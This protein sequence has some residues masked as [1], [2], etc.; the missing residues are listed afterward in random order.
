MSGYGVLGFNSD[1]AGGGALDYIQ[2]AFQDITVPANS[3]AGFSSTVLKNP[4]G[5]Y[6]GNNAAPR[7]GAK[8]LWIKDLVPLPPEKQ[9]ATYLGITQ[10]PTYQI[11][12]HED[13]PQAQGYMYGAPVLTKAPADYSQTLAAPGP[14]GHQATTVKIY[15]RG[16]GIGVTGI[17]RRVQWLVVP[18]SASSLSLQLQLD[19][20]DTIT[21]AVGGS[22]VLNS[23]ASTVTPWAAYNA[24]TSNEDREIH[25][26]RA[27]CTGDNQTAEVVGCVVYYEV[28]GGAIDCFGGS[29][30]LN[31][32]KVSPVGTTLALPTN[33]SFRGGRA[34]IYATPAAGF[35]LTTSFVTDIASVATG[36]SGTNLLSV[37]PGTGASFP[38]GTLVFIP[39][40]TDYIG[41]VLSQ[42]S[43]TLTMGVTLPVGMSNSIYH[44]ASCGYSLGTAYQLTS[45]MWE[46]AWDWDCTRDGINGFSTTA[47]GSSFLYGCGVYQDPYQRFRIVGSTF[48]ILGLSGQ[49]TGQSNGLPQYNFGQTNMLIFPGA[50]SEIRVQGKF[51]ALEFEWF[52]GISGLIAGT[53]SVGGIPVLGLNEGQVGGGMA[54]RRYVAEAGQGFNSVR[55]SSGSSHAGV[56]IMRITGYRSKVPNGPSFGVLSELTLGQTFLTRAAQNATLTAFG[57]VQRVYADQLPL[58]GAWGRGVT[59]GAAGGVWYAGSATSDTGRFSYYGTQ[60][61]IVGTQGASFTLAVNGTPAV[62][63]FNQWQGAALS[64]GFQTITFN[65]QTGISSA[66]EAIDF[67]SADPE[68]VNTQKFPQPILTPDEET[69]TVVNGKVMI[70]PKGVR[71][72]HLGDGAVTPEK[73]SAV[74]QSSG[75]S[76]SNQTIVG[77]AEVALA[78]NSVVINTTGRPVFVGLV[79]ADITQASFVGASQPT[80]AGSSGYCKFQRNGVTISYHNVNITVDTAAVENAIATFVPPG[81]IW[82]VDTPPAGRHTYTA[83]GAGGA[84]GDTFYFNYVKLIAHEM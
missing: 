64:L 71:T 63:T 16:D 17:I 83:V 74:I 14:A 53:L 66:I 77:V 33:T 37:S 61:C 67:L 59:T 68:I 2:D 60:F 26:F 47:V 56:G 81:A 73:L 7:Y 8:V 78:N 27:F 34:A 5:Y 1:S 35:G 22:A 29:T 3:N 43:D 82:F 62:A 40:S 18:S 4:M 36:S 24:Q 72:Q 30:Y 28:S 57:N 80:A 69:L 25:D 31:K 50:G 45:T 38:L 70:A 23:A 19:G 9:T 55:F 12:W 41:S 75:S 51:Q 6:L 10:R 79:P 13:F 15:R 49:I 52:A 42:S 21:I 58:F 39:G 54:I 65:A 44:I 84:A 11:V 76:S 48:Q 20:S 32:A 46:R